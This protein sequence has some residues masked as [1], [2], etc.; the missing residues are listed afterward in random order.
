MIARETHRAASARILV[1]DDEEL[2]LRL[3]RRILTRAG[4]DNVR[5][6]S[7]GRDV[8]PVFAEFN[9]DV[10]LLDLHMP[11]RNGFEVLKDL[12]KVMEPRG[13][14][15]VLMLT[16]D[17]SADAKRGALSLGAKDFLAKPFDASEVVLRIHN[18]LETR[19][20]YR[21]LEDQ[22]LVL[23]SRVD[24]RTRDLQESRIEILERLARAAEIRDDDT[25]RHIVRVGELS[26]RLAEAAGLSAHIVELIRR[27]AP[28]HDVGK[29]G[30]P[31]S[32]L[33]KPGKLTHE[34]LTLM[35]THAAIGA[36][37]L[38]GGSSELVLVAERIALG[39]HE[40]WNGGGYPAGV[41]GLDIPVEARCV[42]IADCFDALS[43]DRPYREA[44]PLARVLE[45]IQRCRGTQFDPTLVD[46]LMETQCYRRLTLTPALPLR[47][48]ET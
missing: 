19:M 18:L 45:E 36:E 33:H 43:H 5:L 39:H 1:V 34:E 38:S 32:V 17:A 28:L 30:I 21:S 12:R 10:I 27:T 29:I 6:I 37:I 47:K 20:L 31:D 35:R 15:P 9:P 40:W 7:D 11:N 25:G 13:F 8:L 41:A 14:L 22:N 16:G 46:A 3:L 24:E 42:A 48:L 23:E 44:W 4:Y 26:A 2:N